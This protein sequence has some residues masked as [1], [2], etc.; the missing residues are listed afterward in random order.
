MPTLPPP[1]LDYASPGSGWFAKVLA[2]VLSLGLLALAV[3]FSL[4]ALVVV[5][6]GG[7]ALWG[8]LHWKT[9]GLRRQAAANRR[10]QA[11]PGPGAGAGPQ[12]IEGE[13]MRQPDEAAHQ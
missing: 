13:C 4:A 1:R 8:W 11:D 10:A 12:I 3:V 6:V 2:A 9:R 7:L 5:A